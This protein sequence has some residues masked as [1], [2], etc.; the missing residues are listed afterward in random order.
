MSRGKCGSGRIAR[1]CATS[2]IG[3]AAIGV[4]L[5]GGP[6]RLVAQPVIGRVFPATEFAARRAAVMK[7]VG[8]G[9]AILQGTTE[10]PGE[11]PLRQNDEFYYL[12]G[13]I[14]PRAI[15]VIDGRSKRS[16]L[17][18]S[19][20]T[21]IREESM[22]GP[23]LTPGDSAEKDTGIESVVAR[24][25]FGSVLADNIGTGGRT[26]FAP[27]RPEV[28]GSAS[29]GDPVALARATRRDPW[30][31]RDSRAD[32]F[33]EKLKSVATSSE[34]RDLDPIIDSLRAIKSPR[35][36]EVIHEATRIAG[37]GIME[38]M[39]DAKPGMREYELQADAEFVFKK[40]GAY[41]PAYFALIATGKN[42]YYTHYHRN[43]AVLKDGDLVQ[44]DYAPDY[45]YYTSDVTR[46]F[47]ANG[48]F[49]A[50]QKE[51]YNVYLR[52]YQ[53]LMTSIRP[54][55]TPDQIAK[56]AVVKMEKFV[57]SYP[58]TEPKIKAAA[59]SFIDLYRLKPVR[60]LGHTV[61][62]SVHDV[63]YAGTTLQPGEIFTIEPEMRIPDEHIGFRLEDM[64]LITRDG[65]VN[66]SGFVP[67]EVADIERLMSQRGLS[68]FE[69]K[70]SGDKVNTGP[71]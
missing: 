3:A 39:R 5:F 31:G 8:D 53:A 62:M 24:D 68:D 29:S 16:T 34:I 25:R 10:R 38:A 42:T 17:F 21:T 2:A 33:R 11:Q 64:L 50:R 9:V 30:D 57:A 51:M 44:F 1:M 36:I 19:P 55:Q 32:A 23:S 41:G 6:A 43:T 49:T 56:T 60:S 47:P 26:I 58:F 46:I 20:T 13:V 61:G 63:P 71:Q 12:T 66:L 59:N 18:L 65:Y 4:A 27:F 54:Y 67:V 14:E 37:L 69:L 28:L 7:A 45:D 52:L 35:E 15:L 22:F 70:M 48:K 40:H